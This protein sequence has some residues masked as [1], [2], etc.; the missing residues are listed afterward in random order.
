MIYGQRDS[1][2]VPAVRIKDMIVRIY[3]DG[4][5]VVLDGKIKVLG[6][7][8]NVAKSEKRIVDH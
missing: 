8:G 1:L 2:H 7:K 3:L 4:V 5:A 6:G